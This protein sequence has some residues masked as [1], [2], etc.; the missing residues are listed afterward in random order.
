[1]KKSDI[2]ST[3]DRKMSEIEV[4]REEPHDTVW[5]KCAKRMRTMYIGLS[6]RKVIVLVEATIL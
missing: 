4:E 5:L 2:D 3:G 6:N 1:M